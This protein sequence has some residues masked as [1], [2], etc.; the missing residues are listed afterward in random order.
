MRRDYLGRPLTIRDRIARRV[1]RVRRM[2]A[3][4]LWRTTP[5]SD[6]WGSD[7]GTPVDR[8]YIER[9]LEQ[10]R[11]LIRGRVLEIKQPHYTER[12]GTDVRECDVLD[13][14]PANG[15]ATIVADLAS[16]DA[17]PDDRFDCFILTQTLQFVYDLRAA[18][19]HSHRILRPG[20]VLLCTV[21]CV[22]RIEPGSVGREY[23]RFTR[24]SCERLFAEAFGSANVV[25]ASHGNALTSIAF[26][27]G[28]AREELRTRQ[29]ER[30]DAHFPLIIS[31]RAQKQH[32][33]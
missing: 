8:F 6:Y 31:V 5:L 21:P 32:A 33:L 13:V 3:L 20:G 4:A 28:M 10:N 16:A 15:R 23:W 26:L 19:A 11:H 17:V 14:D 22:S 9:F 27:A 24:A 30:A 2:R 18:V 25:V 29:L 1:R 7:R 12:Y